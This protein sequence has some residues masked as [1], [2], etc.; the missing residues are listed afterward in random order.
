MSKTSLSARM[1]SPRMM[2]LWHEYER[3][4]DALD[5]AE[6]DTVTVNSA[7]LRVVLELAVPGIWLSEEVLGI[8]DDTKK[9]D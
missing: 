9:I 4:R 1:L 2:P 6:G 7:S 3:V 8:C 5:L